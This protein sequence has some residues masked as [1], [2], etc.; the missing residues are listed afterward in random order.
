MGFRYRKRIKI[1][2]GIYLNVGTKSISLSLKA[3]PVSKTFSSTGRNTTSVNLPGGASY[4][5]S[6]RRGASA[7]LSS[8]EDERREQ[9]R[10]RRDAALARREARRNGE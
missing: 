2:P 3:G 5:T 8:T 1:L 4:R 9:L 6:R 10:A 7:S